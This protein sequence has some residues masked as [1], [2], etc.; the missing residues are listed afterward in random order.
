MG[1]CLLQSVTLNPNA[2]HAA[3]GRAVGNKNISGKDRDA[4]M[5]ELFNPQYPQT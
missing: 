1:Y 2:S 3:T 4:G 5:S